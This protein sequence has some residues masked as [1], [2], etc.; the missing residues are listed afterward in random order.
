MR[1]ALSRFAVFAA[2]L[3]ALV[4]STADAQQKTE[5][6]P[7]A[8]VPAAA[9]ADQV[10]L[11]LIVGPNGGLVE[12]P[13][14]KGQYK[15]V[16]AEF[17]RYF[18]AKYGE[19]LK[20]N[21]GDDAKP[22][23]EFLAA[24]PELR[25][26]L[27]TAI[28]P[29][30]DNP[31]EAMAVLR[32]LWKADP[33]AVKANDE[34]A[35]AVAVVWDNPRGVY[36]YRGHQIRTK[37]T[38]PDSVANVKAVEN[39]K[40]VLDRQAKLKGPQQQL[41]WEFLVHTV[42]HKTPMDERDWSITNYLS[43]AGH[44][45]D[46]QGHRVR[47]G[48]AAT[49]SQVCGTTSRTRSRASA[50]T[51]ACAMGGLRRAW[52]SRCSCRPS[53]SAARRT[54]GGL[55]AWVMWVEVK[56]VQKETVTFTLESYGRYFG[57]NYY[58]GTLLDPKTGKDMTDR[59]LERRLTAVGTAPFSSRQA[60]LLMRAYPL[61]REKKELT[62]KQQLAYLNKVLALYPMCDAA[63]LEL[64]ALHKGGKLTDSVEATRLVDKAL[65]T[66]AKFPDFS[67]KLVDELL[68]PQKDKQYR[69]RTFEKMVASYETLAARL[70][71]E[72]RMKLVDQPTRR[73]LR[74]RSTAWRSPSASSRTRGATSRR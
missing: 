56:S 74:K 34:L 9:E 36:D 44:R 38:L 49:Q 10:L 4:A 65:L 29:A 45:H 16:R 39:F 31:A 35:V 71:C 23:F 64:A 19:I 40:F 20:A 8:P 42:N 53:T 17:A 57:D 12:K 18:E 3:F 60:D 73:T 26:T 5:P 50:T 14:T 22:L 27:F 32:D 13:F 2:S 70:G 47:Q 46:L 66:F 48:D 58:V 51:A 61:V 7:P 68:T 15:H 63:W 72:A 55:H 41:P 1:P 28:D 21:L 24:N 30:A 59:D 37:S 54:P 43:A 62:T 25:D 69:T 6:K 52:R 67:W 33:A 11:E